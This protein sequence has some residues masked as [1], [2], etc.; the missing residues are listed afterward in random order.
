MI[1]SRADLVAQRAE[2]QASGRKVVFTNGCFDLLHLGHVR[3]LEEARALGDILV[4]GLNSDAS[5]RQLKGPQRP[6]VGQQERAEVMSALRPVDHVVIFE[7][8][9][10]ESLV[11]ELQ[12]DFY[13]KGGDYSSSEAA[14]ATGKPLP[15][16]AV[17]RSYGGQVVLIPFL[18]GHSTSDLVR[19]ILQ[20]YSP[21]S[22]E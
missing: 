7:D 12:P 8:L 17:V 9:T 14:S 18:P 4:L 1:L 20:A 3:Y 2:W 11:G 13:V 16:A 19:H 5:V 6:L 10:A 22:P 15:E 21:S